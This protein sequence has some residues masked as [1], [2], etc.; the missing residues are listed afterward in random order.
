MHLCLHTCLR[1]YVTQ[2]YPVPRPRCWG[3]QIMRFTTSSGSFAMSK[4]LKSELLT[5]Q[6]TN[7]SAGGGNVVGCVREKEDGRNNKEVG[8]EKER[9]GG[10][11]ATLRVDGINLSPEDLANLRRH[12]SKFYCAPLFFYYVL[13]LSNFN[14]NQSINQ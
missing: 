2:M 1:T 3:S 11:N 13:T 10:G 5:A 7:R 12:F 9:E 14:I 4:V 8:R 6:E